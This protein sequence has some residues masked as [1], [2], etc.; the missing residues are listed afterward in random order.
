MS[1]GRGGSDK[2]ANPP[3]IIYI[4]MTGDKQIIVPSN[5]NVTHAS[6]ELLKLLFICLLSPK[7]NSTICLQNDLLIQYY[8]LNQIPTRGSQSI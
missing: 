6:D 5:N 1:G 2:T 8:N 7:Y 4:K 3:V